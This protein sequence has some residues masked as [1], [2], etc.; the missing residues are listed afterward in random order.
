MKTSLI[1]LLYIIS[2]GKGI[3]QGNRVFSGAELINYDIVDIS[4]QNG[5]TWSTERYALPGYFSVLNSAVFTGCSDIENIDGYIKKYGNTSFIFPVGNGND[6]RTLEIS[7]PASGSDAYATAW[8]VGDP[9]LDL[10]PTAPDAGAHPVIAVTAP[11]SLVSSV[12]QWD[13]QVGEASHL[14][15]GTTG[16][17]TGLTI[18]VSIP[19]MNHFAPAA[20]L[21]LVGW[22]GT[23]WI[24]LS[25][26]P[27]ASG[28]TENSTLSG[29]M[30]AGITAIA[31]GRISQTLSLRLENFTVQPAGCSA[32]LNWKTSAEV[33]T[34]SFVVEQSFDAVQ[35]HEVATVLAS[36]SPAGSNY[37]LTVPQLSNV[38]YYR[39]KMKDRDGS[40]SY[41]PLL[42]CKT[43]CDSRNSIQVYPNPVESNQPVNVRFTTAYRGK[44]V[45]LILNSLG[46]RILAKNIV[47]TEGTNLVSTDVSGLASATYFI[48]LIGADGTPIGKG[49]QFIIQ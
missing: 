17:G 44:A 37:S 20:F 42:T 22:N 31:I 13:W 24:D 11:I 1:I 35:F 4:V 45:F 32:V 9:G 5:L 27:T 46:Q 7:A 34:Y 15:S 21:R 8:I 16:A 2:L 6:L 18:T 47:V 30:V 33:N 43:A 40:Y 36:G 23:R 3:A 19:D 25:G 29:T 14:G 41:S 49:M 26:T 28:N 10:D 39:L 38:A 48:R 12:G